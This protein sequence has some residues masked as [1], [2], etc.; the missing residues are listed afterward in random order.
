MNLFNY[1][2]DQV[3]SLLELAKFEENSTRRNELYAA[4]EQLIIRDAP[5]R[6]VI[7]YRDF[8]FYK[9]YI[10]GA[11]LSRLGIA[12]LELDKIY[13]DTLLYQQHNWKN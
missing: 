10:K 13:I 8:V 12:S 9:D 5:M 4:A 11:L 3:D 2:N 7:Y 6:P 1:A